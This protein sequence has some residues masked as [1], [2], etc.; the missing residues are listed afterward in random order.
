MDSLVSDSSTVLLVP[1]LVM[2]NMGGEHG[3][4][5]G[6]GENEFF[7]GPGLERQSSPA[8]SPSCSFLK[9][10]LRCNLIK[11]FY[12]KV[13][14]KKILRHREGW[15]SVMRNYWS[16]LFLGLLGLCFG[17]TIPESSKIK[18]CL[19]T[20][21]HHLRAFNSVVLHV[22]S[23]LWKGFFTLETRMNQVNMSLDSF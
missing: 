6:E 15:S 12:Q 9:K 5:W 23:F 3:R 10:P 18:S 4:F 1:F 21:S 11:P 22:K 8:L 13:L 20:T 19:F 7:L 14:M 16:G 17:I 2:D